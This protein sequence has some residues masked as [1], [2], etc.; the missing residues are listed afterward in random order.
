MKNEILKKYPY[1]TE[2]H[3]HTRPVSGCSDF[4]PEELVEKMISVGVNTVVLTNHFTYKHIKDRPKD[5]F[6]NEY[7]GAYH[8]LKAAA[9]ARGMNAV[10]GIELR[11][12][13]SLNEYLIYGICEADVPVIYDYVEKGIECFYKEFKRDGVLI[14]Q[15]HPGRDKM[16]PVDYSFLDGVEAFNMHPGHNSRASL[17][18]R[19]ANK[20]G[21]LITGGTDFHHDGHEGACL[22]RSAYEIKTAEDLVSVL[23][24]RD[25]CLDVFGSIILP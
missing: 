16:I 4:Y 7:I 3:A 21:M 18:A 9:N 15:A 17:I 12:A 8:D 10:F 1:K 19:A 2:L 22:M 23:S 14:I 20:A 13:E 11:F 5:D 24:S 6:V 25:F